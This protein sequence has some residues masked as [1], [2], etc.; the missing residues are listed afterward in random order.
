MEIK[1][2][3]HTGKIARLPRDIRQQINTRLHEGHHGKQIVQWLNALPEVKAIL[4]ENFAARPI[5]E[6]NLSNW[7]R[8]GYQEWLAREEMFL[9]A[10]EL[11]ALRVK[12]ETVAPGQSPTDHVATAIAFRFGAILATQG[13]ELDAN[14]LVQLK[15]LARAGYAVA[16][17]RQTDQEAVRL[18]I[19][20]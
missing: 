20:T 3:A 1:S 6:Q 2:M 13:A 17:L 15:A 19:E 9:Q 11:A 12:L 14:S 7:R 8:G 10:P 16:K 5:K 4:A 18:K